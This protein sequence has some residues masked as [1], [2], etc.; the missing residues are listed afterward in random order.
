MTSRGKRK[1]RGSRSAGDRGRGLAEG[2]S[3]GLLGTLFGLGKGRSREPGGWPSP[4]L[5]GCSVT[6]PDSLGG[7]GGRAGLEEKGSEMRNSSLTEARGWPEDS[8]SWLCHSVSVRH[9]ANAST[10]LS[11]HFPVCEVGVILSA[12]LVGSVCRFN[13]ITFGDY[14]AR[15]LERDALSIKGSELPRDPAQTPRC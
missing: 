7:W 10:S 13:E 1:G 9:W 11:L 14:S 6:G 5:Q 2:Q 15:F 12:A 4:R 8:E 3:R